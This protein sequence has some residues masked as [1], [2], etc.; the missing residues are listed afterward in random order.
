LTEVTTLRLG[1]RQYESI[2]CCL[3]SLQ[4]HT[5][6]HAGISCSVLDY[7]TTS[8]TSPSWKKHRVAV[9]TLWNKLRPS[10]IPQPT[11]GCGRQRSL[12]QGNGLISSYRSC[13]ISS[14]QLLLYVVCK[15]P[16]LHILQ[17]LEQVVESLLRNNVICV[18]AS[19][20]NEHFHF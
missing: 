18:S 14:T 4:L 2:Q 6:Q 10:R 5:L 8:L 3:Q 1:I 11:V 19:A 13:G 15:S 9:L 16:Q 7:A 17:Q 20:V 12:F